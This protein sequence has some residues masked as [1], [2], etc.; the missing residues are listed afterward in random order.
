MAQ[1][2]TLD[3][4]LCQMTGQPH[5]SHNRHINEAPQVRENTLA[6][7]L[8]LTPFSWRH[9]LQLCP[10]CCI[11]WLSNTP[12]CVCTSC[13]TSGLIPHL[14]LRL[15]PQEGR[16]H[17]WLSHWWCF[18][19]VRSLEQH[20][21][22]IRDIYFLFSDKLHTVFHRGC[23]AMRSHQ[24]RIRRACLHPHQPSLVF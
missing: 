19:Q 12:S 17:S 22:V 3:Y 11:L 10:L 24:E 5:T 23:T 6:V 1:W 16:R 13:C 2:S 14:L 8:G 4:I 21:Q 18:L 20:R 9:V 7:P 15:K